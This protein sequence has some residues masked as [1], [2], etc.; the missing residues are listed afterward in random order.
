MFK[1]KATEKGFT[2]IEVLVAL[3]ITSA[4][5]SVMSAAVVLIM[6]TT[7]QNEEWNVNLRQVQNA[8]Y[9][10]SRDALMAQTVSD[11]KTGVFLALSWS[12]WDNNNYN[13]E[14]VFQGNT[15]MRRLNGG[16]ATLIAQY[17]M[18]S[19]TCHWYQAENK[20]TV[21]IKASLHG[22]AGRSLERT[23]EIKPRPALRGG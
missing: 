18:Q 15:L 20:L 2:L 22:D 14:Y 7:S 3:V 8:G 23:Y 13:V 11:N 12:D 5:L 21:T 4:I 9:W 17:I 19:T 10:I 1:F 6:R 16:S